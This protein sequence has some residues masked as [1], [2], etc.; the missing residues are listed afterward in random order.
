MPSLPAGSVADPSEWQS[1]DTVSSSSEATPCQGG[2][3]TVVI[4]S[5]VLSPHQRV[6]MKIAVVGL[7]SWG[8]SFLE[9]IVTGSRSQWGPVQVHVVEPGT[10]GSGVYAVDQPDYLILNTPCGQVS[11]YPWQDEGPSPKYAMGL[12][13]WLT[14]VGYRWVGESCKIDQSGRDITRDDYVPRR[15]MGEYLQWFYATLVA[16]APAKV[17]IVHHHT[18]ATNIVSLGD[19]GERVWLANGESLD[20]DHVILT[21]GH[22][23]NVVSDADVALIPRPYPVDRYARTI[24][25]GAI[26]GVEGMGLVATDVITALT[27][28]RGG[29]YAVNGDRLRYLPSGDEPRLRLFS[30]SGFPYYSKAVATVDESDQ[31]EAVVCTREAIGAVQG[32]QATGQPRRQ[33]DFRSQVLPLIMAEMQIKYYAQSA[34]LAGGRTAS[35]EVT[36]LTGQAWQ[37]GS[38]RECRREPR[39]PLRRVRPLGPFLRR[40]ARVRLLQGLRVAD[41][42]VGRVGPE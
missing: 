25:A 22:T 11:L 18:E 15:L 29:S 12:H 14:T 23:N 16:A 35:D 17:E 10:P 20:V 38:Y 19:R 3:R 32:G 8:L 21:S 26:V 9:R 37:D 13:E 42:L 39:P 28:G 4:L 24:P 34:L 33:I 40:P 5:D 7:G 31:F 6:L 36:R 1:G 27:L 30:R 2:S 41:L